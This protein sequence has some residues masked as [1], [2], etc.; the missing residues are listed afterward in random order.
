MKTNE[1][2]TNRRFVVTNAKGTP[3]ELWRIYDGRGTAETFIDEFRNGLSMDRLSLQR[4]LA[5]AFRLAL[6][7]VRGYLRVLTQTNS[8]PPGT[9]PGGQ[10]HVKDEEPPEQVSGPRIPGSLRA[11]GIFAWNRV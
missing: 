5:N 6:A 3:R 10:A 7:E 11:T 4:F 2:G 9:Q 1:Q 8:G